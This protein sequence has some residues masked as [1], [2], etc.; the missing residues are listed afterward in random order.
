MGRP[1]VITVVITQKNVFCTPLLIL[2]HPTS[3]KNFAK[4][5]NTFLCKKMHKIILKKNLFF[6]FLNFNLKSNFFN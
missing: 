1:S 3:E 4:I 5:I 6:E 2:A